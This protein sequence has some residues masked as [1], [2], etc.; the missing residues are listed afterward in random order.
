MLTGLDSSGETAKDT[1]IGIALLGIVGTSA[2][3]CLMPFMLFITSPDKPYYLYSMLKCEHQYWPLMIPFA[4]HEYLQAIHGTFSAY[5]YVF[6]SLVT[7]RSL[8]LWLQALK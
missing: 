2:V 8:T 6:S 4:I 3:D 7:E 5:F 1:L